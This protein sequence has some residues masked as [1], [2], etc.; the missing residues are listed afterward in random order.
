[1]A[2]LNWNLGGGGSSSSD[3]GGGSTSSDSGSTVSW[4]DYGD[5]LADSG[6]SS[7]DAYTDDPRTNADNW[8]GDSDD[9]GSD[10]SVTFEDLGY[11]ETSGIDNGGSSSGSDSGSSSSYSQYNDARQDPDNWDGDPSTGDNDGIDDEDGDVQEQASAWDELNV[12]ANEGTGG[13]TQDGS[14]PGESAQPFFV[15]IA[16]D[17]GSMSPGLLV[18]AGLLGALLLS[19]GGG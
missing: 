18:G 17:T 19:G 1:M 15:P 4:D 2:Q 13:A 16:P 6:G 14:T 11:G 5:G 10:D 9:G 3:D 12:S 8:D 7:T